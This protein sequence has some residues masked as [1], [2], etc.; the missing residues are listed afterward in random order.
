VT[1]QLRL[2]GVVENHAS[3]EKRG[4]SAPEFPDALFQSIASSFDPMGV[5][6]LCDAHGLVP[7]QHG[8]V[9]DRDPA[10]EQVGREGVSEQP[11]TAG[12][13]D[14]RSL[15]VC[16][17]EDRMPN[18]LKMPKKSQVL[19]LLEL[20]WSYRRIE[21]EN[22]RAPRNG[23]PVRRGAE[24]TGTAFSMAAIRPPRAELANA[25]S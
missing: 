22:R 10:R 21:A 16:A 4:Q 17:L 9:L 23:E 1:R 24:P 13:G 11:A 15:R 5:V 14:Q 2:I 8:Y 19:A 25:S 12:R 3:P 18:Y 7:E 20:G 6:G